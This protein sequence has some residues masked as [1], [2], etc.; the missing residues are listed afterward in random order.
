MR[1]FVASQNKGKLMEIGEVLR[2]LPLA[3]V[4]PGTLGIADAPDEDGSTFAENALLKA[5]WGVTV[6]RLP[7]I[8]DDS[9]IEVAALPGEL[10]VKTRRW[11]AGP[12]ASDEEWIAHF[13]SRMK[14]EEN[15]DARFVCTIGYVDADGAEHTFEGVCRGTITRELEADYLPGLPFSACFRPEGCDRVFSALTIEQKNRT[16]HRGRALHALREFLILENS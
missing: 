3:L 11:G 1:L 15:R 13:L 7:S 5:R 6:S 4:H 9:G 16:S 10:G 8:G 2:G 14:N 12:L